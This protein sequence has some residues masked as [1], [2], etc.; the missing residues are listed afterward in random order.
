MIEGDGRPWK[1]VEGEGLHLHAK[2]RSKTSS[3]SKDQ[4]PGTVNNSVNKILFIFLF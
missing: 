3:S 4:V 2:T 1:V